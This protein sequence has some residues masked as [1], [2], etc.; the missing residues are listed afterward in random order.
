MSHAL[1]KC[2][3]ILGLGCPDL[4]IPERCAELYA[5][6]YADIVIFSGGLGK[7]T[8]GLWSTSEA[9]KFAEIALGLG[10]PKQK[11]YIENKSANTG[12]NIR[13]TQA[14]IERSGLLIDSF[15]I[16]HKPFMTRRS[17]ATFSAVMPDKRCIVTSPGISFEAYFAEYGREDAAR[18]EL[19]HTIAGDLQRIEVYARRGWQ[20]AQPM[21]EEVWQAYEALLTLGYDKY[22]IAP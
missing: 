20:I 12:E 8:E 2:D 3:C 10:A 6:G 16:V 5:Q 11:I 18:D 22:V 14:L 13:F 15:L 21:P 9:E 7:G 19:I 17:Y 1:E 4:H